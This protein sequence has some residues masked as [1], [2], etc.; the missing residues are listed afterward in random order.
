MKTHKQ[1]LIETMELRIAEIDSFT[2]PFVLQSMTEVEQQTRDEM[3]EFVEWYSGMERK[4]INNA[5]LRYLNEKLL[6]K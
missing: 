6:K 5:Y 4:K 1:I 3:F 2:M